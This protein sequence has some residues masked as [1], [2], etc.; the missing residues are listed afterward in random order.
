M[1]ARFGL[2]DESPAATDE[3]TAATSLLI[4]RLALGLRLPLQPELLLMQWV[5]ETDS[6][7]LLQCFGVASGIKPRSPRDL[8]AQR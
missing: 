4:D 7:R 6:A 5:V 3:V 8:R 1:A 2:R